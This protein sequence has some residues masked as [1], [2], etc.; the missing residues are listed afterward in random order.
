MKIP[1]ESDSRVLRLAHHV[2]ERPFS[3]AN[4]RS[5]Y[6]PAATRALVLAALLAIL[7]RIGNAQQAS[8]NASQAGDDESLAEQ[9]VD[10]LA[11]LTQIQIKDPYTPA[12]Y[13]TD[14]QPNTVQIRSIF[15][16]RPFAFIP[17]EQLLRPTIRVVTVPNGKGPST[18][19]AYD[20]MQLLDLFAMPWPDSEAT[21]F[22]WGIGSYFVFP[23]ASSDRVGKGAW[24]MGPAWAFSYRGIPGFKIA[25]L[26][27]QATSFA[28]TSS[29]STPVCSLSFQPIL[30]YQLGHGWYLKSSD[31]TWTFNLR[32]NTSTRM[33]LSAGFGK[34]WVLSKGY[35]IDT[36]ASGEW[37]A[38]RQFTNRTEQFTVN[39]QIGLLIPK[40]EL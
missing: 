24:Q 38:Y 6:F 22:S 40:L 33:P 32:H 19:T 30:S 15:A 17:V 10:P 7:P 36:S 3:I 39:F 12:E 23:T 28:Y 9:V 27:Q 13:G 26:L 21:R 14:A 2:S 16:I 8:P 11:H 20:D 25:G 1:V 5:K 34:V 29:K 18:T 4:E 31:A 35:A 37:M